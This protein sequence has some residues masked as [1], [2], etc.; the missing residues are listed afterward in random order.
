MKVVLTPIE[1]R[2]IGCLLEKEVTTPE[3]YPLSINALAN[4]C[5]QKSNRHPV[6]SLDEGVVQQTVDDLRRR[7]LVSDRSGYGGRVA[8]YKQTFCNTEFGP[9]QF[10][11]VERAIVCELLLRGPQSPGELRARCQRMAPVPDIDAI[12]AALA[13]LATHEQG[14]FVLRLPRAPGMREARYAHLLGD[15]IGEAVM[16]P[17]EGAVREDQGDGLAA[18]IERLEIKVAQLREE[19]A[20]LRQNSG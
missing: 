1:A 17:A 14:P 5:N 19:L 16:A 6:M 7:H 10:T 2:V 13:N 3:Q 18:R 9:L 4:A 12:E 15:E 11:D 8:K 20:Q